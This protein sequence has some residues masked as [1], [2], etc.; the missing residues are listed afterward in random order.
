MTDA[1][2]D[3]SLVKGCKVVGNSTEFKLD[4]L[5]IILSDDNDQQDLDSDED[6]DVDADGNTHYEKTLITDPS[7]KIEMA[8]PAKL[9]WKLTSMTQSPTISDGRVR[10][11]QQN[12]P[13][14]DLDM[15]M[16]I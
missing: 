11:T 3:D 1:A 10:T 15:T 7:R 13:L 14:A 6:V 9:R 16:L 4:T 12:I 2:F 5:D 8:S